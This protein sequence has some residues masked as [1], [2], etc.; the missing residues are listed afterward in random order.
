VGE[1]A[2]SAGRD[3]RGE[4]RISQV[5]GRL[6]RAI[7]VAVNERVRPHGL[8][9]LQYRTLAILGAC[10]EL[11][12]AQLA[13]RASMTPQSMSEVIE[14]LEQKELIEHGRHPG[15]RRV[16]PAALTGKG[17]EVLL[18]CQAAIDELE[19][20]M[21]EELSLHRRASLLD[22]LLTAARALA[23]GLPADNPQVP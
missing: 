18:V 12:N 5:V 14:A 6:E 22:G 19:E 8:T 15:H 1:T 10:G 20:E 7:R 9:M 17:R 2:G 21:L 4:Q 11:S 3:G 13:R 16:Y 23:G